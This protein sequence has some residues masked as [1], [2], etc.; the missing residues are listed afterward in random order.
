MKLINHPP[1]YVHIGSDL[2]EVFF[3]GEVVRY[4]HGRDGRGESIDFE[5]LPAYE[6]E[7]I[8][9]V[10]YNALHQLEKENGT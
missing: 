7:E 4:R 6:Q 3:S 10:V 8:Y 9:R 1:I 5:L 2:Y